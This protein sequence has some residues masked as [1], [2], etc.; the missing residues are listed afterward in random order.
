MKRFSVIAISAV[1]CAALVAPA[2]A[3]AAKK[4]R[5]EVDSTVNGAFVPGQSVPVN[6]SDPYSPTRPSGGT[7]TGQVN[8]D[9][10]NCD[11]NRD[12]SVLSPSGARLGGATSGDGGGWSFE[13]ENTILPAGTYTVRAAKHVRKKERTNQ[14]GQRI[15]KKIVCLPA[16]NTFP[17]Q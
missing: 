11:A 17:V 1:G 9:G 8:S 7:F 10:K 13:L 14:R 2:G 5:I 16:E 6:P 4:E 3:L 15:I 12:V